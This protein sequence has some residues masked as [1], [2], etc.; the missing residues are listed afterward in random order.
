MQ[1]FVY[2]CKQG[3][4][5][6]NAQFSALQLNPRNEST[7][8]GSVTFGLEEF[9]EQQGGQSQVVLSRAGLQ[10]GMY[11][12]PNVPIP[13]HSFCNSMHEAAC[14]TGNEHFGLSFGARF[15]PEGLGVFGYHAITAPTLRDA[16]EGMLS[17]FN[18]F[19]KNSL[20]RLTQHKGICSLE[21]RLLDGDIRD[22]RQDAEVTIG[23]LNNVLRRGLGPDWTPL[24]VHFQHPALVDA[25]R[26]RDAYQCDVSFQRESNFIFFRAGCLDSPMPDADPI[27]HGITLDAIAQLSG[28]VA[29]RLSVAQRVRG[30]VVDLLP[31]GELS[32]EQVAERLLQS[33]RTLQRALSAENQSFKTIVE[34]T[35]QELADY[36]LSYDQLSLSQI[37]FRL[38]YSELSAFTRAF[39]RWKNV[40]PSQWRQAVKR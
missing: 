34:V 4:I 11:K 24:A 18:V 19:Q 36:Y 26:H 5:T 23:M 20:L 21:Y 12:K 7:V 33:P 29:Q 30:E 28:S 13:L 15:Q 35:R 40:P 25:L 8:L 17:S 39:M 32:L 9:I 3:P 6:M 10:P 37:A 2:I 38:G 1:V 31:S 22:R 27:L 14:S 16:L